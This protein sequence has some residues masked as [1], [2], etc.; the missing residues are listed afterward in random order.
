M[1]HAV[2]VTTAL[3]LLAAPVAAGGLSD[4]VVTLEVV[5]ADAASSSVEHQDTIF[6]TL[7]I[8]MVLL[9]AAGALF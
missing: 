5:T 3:L 4:P 2:A 1:K 8:V 6:A 7:F 9:N